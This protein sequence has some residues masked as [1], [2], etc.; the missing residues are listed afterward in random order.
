MTVGK[1]LAAGFGLA[2]AVLIAVGSLSY[3]SLARLIDNST[4]QTHTY[5]VLTELEALLSLLKD[6]ETGQRG[7]LLTGEESYLKPYH[8]AKGGIGRALERL[9]DLTRDNPDQRPRLEALKARSDDKLQE[10]Q[11]TIELRKTKDLKD[12]LEVVKMG[13]GKE[14]M[15]EARGLIKDMKD[16]ENRLLDQRSADTKTSTQ[17]AKYTIGLGTALAVV[18]VSLWGFFIARSITNPL[19]QGV[20]QLSSASSEILAS[21]TQQTAGAQEQAAAVSQTVAT[22]DEVTQTSEQSATR[23]RTVV[24]LMHRTVEI[25]KAGG[26]A[27]EDSITAQHRVKEQVEATAESILAL[28]EQAQAIGDIIATVNDIAEQTNLLALNAAIEAS[29]AGEHGKGF[30]VVAGEVKALADQS[31]KATTQVRQIL[32]EI[33][34]ATNTA[35]LSTEEVTKGVA[36]AIQVGSK[37]RETITTLAE[38]LSQAAQA[39]AQIVASAGQQATGMAQIHQAMRNIDQVAKQ[40]VAAM[41][42]TE[43]AAQNLTALGTRLNKLTNA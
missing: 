31:K 27:L 7:F 22:V 11:Q 18:C 15:D 29:R 42:Q 37:A 8:D 3:W 16:E 21:T 35:V 6:A 10:L 13:K 40:N 33:Q 19:R 39:A 26:K 14:I 25:G 34:K 4:W 28:A 20:S 17:I 9:K 24:E 36:A 1:K 38:A 41:R 30:A 12:A 43:Q 2:L 23:A 32:G 5:E